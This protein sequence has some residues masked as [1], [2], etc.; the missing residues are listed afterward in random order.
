MAYVELGEEGD[1]RAGNDQCESCPGFRR[2]KV[3]EK[4][5]SSKLKSVERM[6]EAGGEWGGCRGLMFFQI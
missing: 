4:E 3:W 1:N 2:E 6:M 5:D